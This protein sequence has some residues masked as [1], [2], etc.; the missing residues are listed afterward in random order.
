MRKRRL[1]IKATDIC[2]QLSDKELLAYGLL[3]IQE[4]YKRGPLAKIV[5]NRLMAVRETLR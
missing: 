3:L 1:G 4:R 2:W 5:H